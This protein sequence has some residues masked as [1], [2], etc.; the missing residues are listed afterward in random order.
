MLARLTPLLALAAALALPA[1]ARGQDAERPPAARPPADHVVLIS[2][3]G[4]RPE[5]YLDD[6]WPAPTLQHLARTG[7]HAR[8]VRSVFPSVTYPSHTTMVTGARPGQHGVFTNR[9][10]VPQ[11]RAIDWYWDYSAI[12][13]PT[14][15]TA[16][17]AAGGET[18]AVSWPVTVGAPIDRFVPEVWSPLPLDG[19]WLRPAREGTQPA[20]LWEELERETGSLSPDRLSPRFVSRDDHLADMG[21]YLL[22][23][24]RPRLMAIHFVGTD[25]F[26]HRDGRDSLRVREAV[27]A[28]DRGV[29][30]LV[31]AAERAGILG[32]TTFVIVGDHGFVDTDTALAPNVWLVEAGLRT[33]NP[34]APWR[35]KFQTSGAAALL[36]LADPDDAD[37][38]EQVRALL[39]ALP[40]EHRL[41]FRVLEGEQLA[42][43][44]TDPSV[45]LALSCMPGLT[46]SREARGEPVHPDSGGDHGYVADFPHIQ[47]GLVVWGAATRG[48]AVLEQADLTDVAP[49]V[50]HLLGV[51]FEAP[52]PPA[53][54]ASPASETPT[55][56]ALLAR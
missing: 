34:A 33:A 56:E 2:I 30:R 28:A 27:A 51:P 4:L 16:V 42:A 23:R 47:T 29:S 10:F 50:A 11:G 48:G 21:A 14:L 53:A 13:V 15:W 36:R 35:A 3:D 19:D 44:G 25:T 45:R 55:H 26:Q 32:R 6:T 54:R 8:A 1:S 5:F 22:G 38:L 7:A 40:L 49:L 20:G 46:M 52:A 12:Q 39:A 18:A 17:R 43:L 9:P 31:E 37:A 24:Y 41:L